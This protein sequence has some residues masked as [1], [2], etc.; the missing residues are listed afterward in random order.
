LADL[1]GVRNLAVRAACEARTLQDLLSDG[2]LVIADCEGCEAAILDPLVAPI[3]SDVDLLVEIH[4]FINPGTTELLE[5]RFGD[6]HSVVFIDPSARSGSD[7]PLLAE[8]PDADRAFVLDERRPRG[9]RWGV[10]SRAVV[11]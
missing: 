9:C 2:A 3:L 10:L 7:Y 5:S 6:T 1:N 8:L 11:A 4:D